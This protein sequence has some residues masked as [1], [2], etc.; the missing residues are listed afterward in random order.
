MVAGQLSMQMIHYNWQMHWHPKK[1]ACSMVFD[2]FYDSGEIVKF[3]KNEFFS[4]AFEKSVTANV[5]ASSKYRQTWRICNASALLM[6]SNTNSK[7]CP[8]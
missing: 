5:A 1:V 8:T 3:T 6:N 4:S 2:V 7:R